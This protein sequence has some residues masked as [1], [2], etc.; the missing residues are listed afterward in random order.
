MGHPRSGIGVDD[1]R[2]SLHGIKRIGPSGRSSTYSS[3]D[4]DSL[5]DSI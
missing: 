3:C 4:E 2:E 5:V 1:G